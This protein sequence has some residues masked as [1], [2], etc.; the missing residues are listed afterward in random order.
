[1]FVSILVHN[2]QFFIFIFLLPVLPA[3][4]GIF[5]HSSMLLLGIFS[6]DKS[7]ALSI[8]IEPYKNLGDLTIFSFLA[9][10]GCFILY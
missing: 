7:I 8:F 9:N 6:I 3:V 2:V 1:M 4:S 5:F 10:F